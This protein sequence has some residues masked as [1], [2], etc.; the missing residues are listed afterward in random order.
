MIGRRIG[1][2]LCQGSIKRCFSESL[3]HVTRLAERAYEARVD[4]L[5]L[6]R[7]AYEPCLWTYDGV[8][9]TPVSRRKS[10]LS[11]NA[12]CPNLINSL[13]PLRVTLCLAVMSAFRVE[14]AL[15]TKSISIKDTARAF[16]FSLPDFK[17]PHYVPRLARAE[18]AKSIWLR[19]RSSNAS[20]R[21]KL[22]LYR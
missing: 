1:K 16:A 8:N 18:W 11:K 4:A 17:E 9:A 22:Y 20:S 19:T 3:N 12:Y 6:R 15:V 5:T 13:C 7:P 21:S 10:M 2:L 14:S